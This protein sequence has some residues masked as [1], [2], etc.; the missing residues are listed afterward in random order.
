MRDRAT[1][2]LLVD[3]TSTRTAELHAL[4][5]LA[6]RRLAPA[7]ARRNADR[8]AQARRLFDGYD[9]PERVR[10][11]YRAQWLRMVRRLGARWLALPTVQ[12]MTGPES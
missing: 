1:H 6:A 4:R 9:A 8:V 10:R 11:S 12:R 2:L 7:P 5:T 3:Q